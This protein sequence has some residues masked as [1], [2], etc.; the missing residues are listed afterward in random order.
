MKSR[1]KMR[2]RRRRRRKKGGHQKCEMGTEITN[3]QWQGYEN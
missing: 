2:R 3:S 1:K